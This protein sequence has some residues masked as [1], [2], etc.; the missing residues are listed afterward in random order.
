MDYN[1]ADRRIARVIFMKSS[2]HV[3]T[4]ADHGLDLGWWLHI[5]RIARIEHEAILR[6][7]RERNHGEQPDAG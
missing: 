6:E 7:E 2:E 5:A 3:E 1:E 4:Q